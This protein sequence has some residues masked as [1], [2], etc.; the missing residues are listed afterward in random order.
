MRKLIFWITGS[1][2]ALLLLTSLIGTLLLMA[3]PLPDA[4]TW[5]QSGDQFYSKSEGFRQ[6]VTNVD[7]DQLTVLLEIDPHAPG[8]PEHQHL[9]FDETF[10]VSKGVLSIRVNGVVKQVPAGEKITIARGVLHQ[11]FNETDSIVVVNGAGEGM[12]MPVQFG[13]YLAQLYPLM[14]T[15]GPMSGKVLQQIS[16]W[17]EAFDSWPAG[18]PLPAQRMVRH[19]LAPFARLA[20]VRKTP[21]PKS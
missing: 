6:T 14:D 1:A 7:K 10:E 15:H 12:G 4:Q 3:E 11:P 20:G 18:P 19:I 2:L 9:G 5:F 8:P 16:V 17:G 21:F 13:W